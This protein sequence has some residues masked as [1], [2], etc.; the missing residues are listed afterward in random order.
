MHIFPSKLLPTAY[1]VR[2]EGNVFTRFCP[3]IHPSVCPPGRGTPPGQTGGYPNGEYPGYPLARSGWG[4]PWPGQDRDPPPGQ[5]RMGE[6][7]QG[8]IWVPPPETG[9]NMEYLINGGRYASECVA[10]RWLR[11]PNLSDAYCFYC[12]TD[13]LNLSAIDL[14]YQELDCIHT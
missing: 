14:V 12:Y 11:N 1:V 3:S 7:P 2:R 10:S 4:V 9:Q 13:S 5:V 8:V 6:L